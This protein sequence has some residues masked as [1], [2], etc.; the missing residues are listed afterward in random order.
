MSSPNNRT[1][2][3]IR[4]IINFEEGTLHEA[5]TAMEKFKENGVLFPIML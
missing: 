3:I 1:L 4:E 2:L 5:M